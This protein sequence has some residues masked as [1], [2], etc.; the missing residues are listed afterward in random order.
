MTKAAVLMR[1]LIC[2]YHPEFVH[3]S[4]M[5]RCGLRRPDLFNV[6]RLVEESLSAVGRYEFV[7]A[8]HYDFSDLSD[9]KTT[10]VNLKS[11]QAE[12]GNCE[13]KIGSLRIT[14]YNPHRDRLDFF[15]VPARDLDYVRIPCYGKEAY[16]ERIKFTWSDHSD[17]YNWFEDFRVSTF[18]DLAQA[19]DD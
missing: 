15:Y 9:S 17:H 16:K 2:V 5:R 12:I 18:V 6:E 11:R 7:D 1:D 10:T 14:A 19:V 8:A 3:S 13:G 4:D